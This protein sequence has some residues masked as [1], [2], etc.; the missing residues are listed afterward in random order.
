M[1]SISASVLGWNQGRYHDPL[2][3]VW[4]ANC[5]MMWYSGN[6]S[7]GAAWKCA[8]SCEAEVTFSAQESYSAQ[9]GSSWAQYIQEDGVKSEGWLC[10][11]LVT[12][13][14]S[15][16]FFPVGT[17]EGTCLCSPSQD[18]QRYHGKTSGSCGSGYCHHV[19][20]CLREYCTVLWHLPWNGQRP[21]WTCILTL[22]CPWFDQLIVYAIIFIWEGR[23]GRRRWW[24]W[25]WQQQQQQ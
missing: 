20:V 17:S 16:E 22:R 24:W 13:C 3:V 11:L 2:S 10:G 12:G 5:S 4:Q 6:C 8:S 18:C 9:R 23:G 7:G 1:L 21:L 14:N 19:K 25:W 15:H